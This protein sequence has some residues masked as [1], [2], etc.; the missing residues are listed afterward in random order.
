MLRIEPLTVAAV[1]GIA[2]AYVLLCLRLGASLALRQSGREGVRG[3]ALRTGGDWVQHA[4]V[5]ASAVISLVI[6]GALHFS[7]VAAL[8]LVALIAASGLL[9]RLGVLGIASMLAAALPWLVVFGAVAPK[10]AET[11]TAGATVALVLLVAAPRHDG[12]TASNRL[13][14]G[15]VLFYTSVII[16]LARHPGSAQFIEAAKYIVFPFMV[17]AVTE[18]TNRPALARLSR[19]ALMSGAVAVS[20]NLVLGAAGLNHSYY[21]TGDIEGLAGAHDLALLTGAVTAVS[22]GRAV[23]ARWA[24]LAAIGAIAT[25]ATG[26]RSALP[27][28]VLGVL[29][30]M[31][32]AG[33]RL[34]SLVVVALAAGAVL[35]SG[36][37]N[38]LVA[39]FAHSAQVGEFSSFSS[40]GSGRGSIYTTAIHAWWVSSPLHWLIGTGL[41][42]IES[43][44][45]QATGTSLVGHSD[46]IQVGVELGLMA[47]VG[48]ILMWWTLIARAESKWPLL[49]LVPF[50]LFNGILEYGAPLVVALLFTISPDGVEMREGEPRGS[51]RA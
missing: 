27:G 7:P 28:L 9:V 49:V 1:A 5:A 12:S 24:P 36:V 6:A 43:I 13:R 11:F 2:L 37:T 3:L 17:L 31:F 20:V 18:G 44:E 8:A 32:K 14:L 51:P 19:I 38:V 33:A 50:S 47:L 40:F 21:H 10:L 4:A 29:V 23:R 35:L 16:A 22:L 30:R 34:R 48:L 45:L 46:V 41:R 25:I 15:M 42:S 26:V 39:R